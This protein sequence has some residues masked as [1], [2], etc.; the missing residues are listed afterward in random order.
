MV[1]TF[2]V[3]KKCMTG[4]PHS[5]IGQFA[6]TFASVWCPCACTVS[7]GT[8]LFSCYRLHCIS[9]QQMR[10]CYN[11]LA[12]L[13]PDKLRPCP[14]AWEQMMKILPAS[15]NRHLILPFSRPGMRCLRSEC[16]WRSEWRRVPTFS[17]DE[18]AMNPSLLRSSRWFSFLLWALHI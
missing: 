9:S 1:D 15:S 14:M 18:E 11:D 10:V 2:S 3:R 17:V 16:V 5:Q 8:C 13:L 12:V 6:G 4:Y 7:I